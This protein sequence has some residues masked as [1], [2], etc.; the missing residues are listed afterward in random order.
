MPMRSG[1]G[2]LSSFSLQRIQRDV[3]RNAEGR[4]NLFATPLNQ[5]STPLPCTEKSL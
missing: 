5:H 4:E 1:A 2:N 3:P